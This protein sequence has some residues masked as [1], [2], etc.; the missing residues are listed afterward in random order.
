MRWRA[1]TDADADRNAFVLDVSGATRTAYGRVIG[2]DPSLGVSEGYD[3]GL[4][5]P[6][7]FTDAERA[8]LAE[9]MIGLWQRFKD[10]R[11]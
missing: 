3:G 10:W 9:Y 6:S 11:P 1:E 4:G 7:D 8:E 5:M 2:I